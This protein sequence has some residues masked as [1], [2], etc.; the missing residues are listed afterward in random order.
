MHICI[1]G[2]GAMGGLYG[3]LLSR[4]GVVV[5]ALDS[6]EDH[7]AAI[8]RDGLHLDGITGDLRIPLKAE[9]D[10]GAVA[11]ADIV[12]IQ[13]ST[14][15]TEDA[16]LAA[17]R[18]LKPG[19][20]A[21][22]LQNGVG[23]LETLIAAVG[24]EKVLGGLSYHSAEP[25]GPGHV[26]HTH[27]GPTWIGELDGSRSPRV[28]ALAETLATAGF[29]PTIVDN[30][31]GFIW[32]KFIHNSAINA[33]CAVTGLRVGEI[34]RTPSADR[35]QTHVIEEALAVVA[36]K[37]IVL[38]DADPMA[39]I[40]AFCRKK[41]NKPSMLQHMEMGKRTEID[42]LNGAVV[43]EGRALGIAAPYN[44]ALTMLTKACEAHRAQVLHGPAID[45]AALERKASADVA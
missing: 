35:M 25:K 32:N 4:N 22:T 44:D 26:T 27:A 45:Y 18:I 10:P 30:I 13:T 5:T 34:P 19:G 24:R 36:A 31:E 28:Q 15:A 16:A 20:Y 7:V 29:T 43:R 14:N 39:T 12:F 1:I 33:I 40:K 3:G 41:F 38:P 8:R 2:A 11:P 9:T 21:I 6:W 37:G 42:A 23:N 17:K